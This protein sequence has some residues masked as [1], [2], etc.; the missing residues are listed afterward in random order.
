VRTGRAAKANDPAAPD[1]SEAL[2]AMA[3]RGPSRSSPLYQW[4]EANNDALALAVRRKPPA[5]TKLANYLGEHGV[6]G[7]EGKPP[8]PASVRSAWRRLDAAKMRQRGPSFAETPDPEFPEKRGSG[9]EYDFANA[10]FVR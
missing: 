4:L 9:D 2:A 3:S 6:T 10:P 8:T 5:W 1:L 7:A